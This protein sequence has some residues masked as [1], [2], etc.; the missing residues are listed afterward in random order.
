MRKQMQTG[1]SGMADIVAAVT[2]SKPR[3]LDGLSSS[4][5]ASIVAAASTRLFRAKALMVDQGNLPD[6]IFLLVSGRARFFF[7][8]PD[9]KKVILLWLPPGEICGSAAFMH[10]P[11]NYLV[12]TEA[13]E[14]TFALVWEHKTMR[15]LA[16]QY[17]K[18]IEN[19]L[20]IMTD[21]LVAYRA[22]HIA[23]IS[24]T[25]RERL[26]RVLGNLATGFG[27]ETPA[28]IELDVRNEELA[29]E[30]NVTMFTASRF[31]NEWERM[32]ILEKS[33]GKVLLRSPEQ[34]LRQV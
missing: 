29:N 16:Q 24:A 6:R 34:L 11:M 25:A 33:R 23:L 18:L 5:I 32:G 17:P 2:A 22:T 15:H 10:K 31:L 19:V 20:W 12:S 9:G 28:G 13:V 4:E 26:A 8:T 21:Y 1:P 7:V 3:F 30:A 27:R 14:D